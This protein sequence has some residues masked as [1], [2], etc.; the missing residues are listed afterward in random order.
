[1]GPKKGEMYLVIQESVS[2]QMVTIII[3]MGEYMH[4]DRMVQFIGFFTV[5]IQ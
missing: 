5:K 4:S 1:M 2:T 3:H